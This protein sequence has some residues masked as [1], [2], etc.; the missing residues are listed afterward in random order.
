MADEIDG[1]ERIMQ[2]LLAI[3]KKVEDID[4]ASRNQIFVDT[5]TQWRITVLE[6]DEV[7]PEEPIGN[8]R[9]SRKE[10]VT[11]IPQFLIACGSTRVEVGSDLNVMRARVIKLVCGDADLLALTLNGRGV[12]YGGMNSDLAFLALME[13][14][15]S[16]R[17]RI[18]CMLD[19]SNP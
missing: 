18:L 4:E 11:M 16:L 6:G 3:A 15:M 5:S 12:R 10:L 17:F 9:A 14:K 1:R 19:P 13:G 2:R 7:V 8:S